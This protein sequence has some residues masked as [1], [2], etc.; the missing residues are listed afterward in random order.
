MPDLKK[1]PPQRQY[2]QFYEKAVPVA[3][4]ILTVGVFIMV[5][6]AI[7]VALGIFGN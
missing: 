7:G 5:V 3:I 6:I 2:P 1:T 4:A